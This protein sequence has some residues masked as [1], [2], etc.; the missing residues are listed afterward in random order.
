MSSRY[1]TTGGTIRFALRNTLLALFAAG[2]MAAAPLNVDEFTDF[3]DFS[4]TAVGATP[5]GVL[6]VGANTITGSARFPLVLEPDFF[7]IILP[8]GLNIVSVSINVTLSNSN[9]GS[10]TSTWDLLAP[11]G[12]STNI[13]ADGVFG[14]GGLVINSSPLVF[15]MQPGSG[16]IGGPNAFDYVVTITAEAAGPAVPEPGT[17]VLAAAGLAAVSMLRRRRSA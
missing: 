11:N 8:G 2:V 13:T 15:G 14:L 12:G 7:S 6:D 9:F 4:N 3:G 10:T 5:V 17:W 1:E 16:G